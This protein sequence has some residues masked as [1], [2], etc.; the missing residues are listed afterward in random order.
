MAIDL[1]PTRR[2]GCH[3]CPARHVTTTPG[4][5]SPLHP[6]P[7]KGGLEVPY[8]QADHRWRLPDARVLV[9]E[10][11][12]YIGAELGVRH[13]ADGRAVMAARVERGDGSND[14]AVYAPTARAAQG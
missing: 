7:A 8:V 14:V 1:D 4:P 9:V 12:D 3:D 11:Q 5:I 6:C 10:R 13:D 2:W